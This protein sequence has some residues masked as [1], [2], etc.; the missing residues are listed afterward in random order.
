ML[1]ADVLTLVGLRPFDA[2]RIELELSH[3]RAQRLIGANRG[4]VPWRPSGSIARLQ[5]L[6]VQDFTA[7]EWL[8]IVLTYEEFMRKGHLDLV[9]PRP[10]NVS[11][12][13]NLFPTPR[14]RNVTLAKWLQRDGE[15]LLRQLEETGV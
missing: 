3:E 9:Y 15:N 13:A 12:Y 11:L 4:P 2:K 7:G 1:I 5:N 8:L 6:D 10:E 14:Y